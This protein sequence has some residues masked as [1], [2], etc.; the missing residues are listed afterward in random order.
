[1]LRRGVK[2]HNG[3]PVTAE[4]VKFS[5]ERYR[6]AASGPYKARIASIDVLD[7]QRVRFRFKH[8]G[9]TS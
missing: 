3:E 8:R 6:G 9:P 5:M 2:F 1:V 7:A 4:D